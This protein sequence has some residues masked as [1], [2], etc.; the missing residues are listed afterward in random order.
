MIILMVV[1]IATT[2]DFGPMLVA[3]R[4]TEIYK[5]KDGGD[6]KGKGDS[7]EGGH[8]NKPEDDT[9]LKAWN[10]IFPV[11][12]LVFFIFYLLVKTGESGEA[13]QSLMDK[14][15]ASDSYQALLWGTMAAV[16]CTMLMY[17]LQIVKDGEVLSPLEWP[18]AIPAMFSSTVDGESKPRFLM[19]LSENFESFLFGCGRIFPAIIVLVLAWSVGHVMTV[20]GADRLFARWILGGISAEALPTLSFIIAFFMA[21]ATGTSWGTMSILFPM[22]LLP[23]Y[24]A[25]NGDPTIFYATTAGILSGSVAGD[26]VSPISDTTVLSSLACDCNL[27]AHV[28]TQMGYAIIVSLISVLL[29]TIPIGYDAWPNIIGILTGAGLVVVFVMFYCQP[30]VS[31]SGRY[32]PVTELILMIKARGSGDGGNSVEL[33]KLKED[34]V[35]TYNGEEVVAEGKPL[36]QSDDSDADKEHLMSKSDEEAGKSPDAEVSSGVAE[37]EA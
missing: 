18:T 21:L 25:S 14:I 27:L 23:T 5:R 19:S 9:P 28:S 37:A 35:K 4:K 22:V 7:A 13:G 2:R 16:I 32:D 3:E 24:N 11:L 30:V 1:S 20:V 36:E 12:L 6:G 8:A 33:L 17:F 29:G 10:M 31:A 34:V 26:H 15:E